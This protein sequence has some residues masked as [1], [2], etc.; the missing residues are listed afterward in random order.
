MSVIAQAGYSNNNPY[1]VWQYITA[2]AQGQTT[3]VTTEQDHGYTVGQIVSMRVSQPYGMVEINNLESTIINL[4]PNTFTVDIDS[5]N[6]T[7]FV[8]AGIFK[9]YPA[10]VVPSSSG[11]IPGAIPTQTNLFD[12]FDIIPPN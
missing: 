5:M 6:W 8:N 9:Q 11:I 7:P 3:T 4:T 1:P 12:A 2:I 10:V